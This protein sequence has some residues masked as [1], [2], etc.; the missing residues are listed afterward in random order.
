MTDAQRDNLNLLITIATGYLK[1]A[2]DD[3]DFGAVIM[4]EEALAKYHT[5]L[6]NNTLL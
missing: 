4:W 5:W 6:R 3:N 1:E 2:K